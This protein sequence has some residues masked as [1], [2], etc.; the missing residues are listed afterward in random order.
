ML[1]NFEGDVAE[2]LEYALRKASEPGETF[3]WGRLARRLA[4]SVA[5]AVNSLMVFAIE[6][7]S[8]LKAPITGEMMEAR[9]SMRQ[10]LEASV[11]AAIREAVYERLPPRSKG[12]EVDA[13]NWATFVGDF[14]LKPGLWDVWTSDDHEFYDL[15][16]TFRIDKDGRPT[17]PHRLN[18][19][20]GLEL[21]RAPSLW[22]RM[23]RRGMGGTTQV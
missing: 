20:R 15:S 10:E 6:P 1:S 18:W 8:E 9:N 23:W 13:T 12:H 4:P 17:A 7:L 16:G 5:N 21:L 22:R 11:I 14:N 3:P 19:F 2:A